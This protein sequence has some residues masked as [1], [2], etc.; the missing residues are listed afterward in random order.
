MGLQRAAEGCRFHDRSAMAWQ[1][2][3]ICPLDQPV[4]R[5]HVVSHRAVRW[6]NDGRRPGHDVIAGKG[7]IAAFQCKGHVIGRV[8]GRG[9]TGQPPAVAVD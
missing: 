4:K 9:D 3:G 2:A 5:G 8:A 7:E 1:K 6:G